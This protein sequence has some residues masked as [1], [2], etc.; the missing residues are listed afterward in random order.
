MAIAGRIPKFLRISVII[1]HI[2]E[3]REKKLY[4]LKNYTDMI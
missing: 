2:F 4:D 1:I 3:D